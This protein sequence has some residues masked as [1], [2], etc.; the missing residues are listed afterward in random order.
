MNRR[1][2]FPQLFR[3]TGFIAELGLCAPRGFEFSFGVLLDFF[4]WHF[5]PVFWLTGLSIDPFGRILK[6]MKV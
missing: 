2:I 3:Y 4:R 6:M 5:G 1:F